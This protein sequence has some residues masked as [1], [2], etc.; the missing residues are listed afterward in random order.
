MAVLALPHAGGPPKW[1]RVSQARSKTEPPTT[2]CWQAAWVGCHP[3]MLHPAQNPAHSASELSYLTISRDKCTHA[4]SVCTRTDIKH[5][6][7]HTNRYT[8]TYKHA[9]TCNSATLAT[10][11]LLS[12][13]K[14][15]EERAR[16]CLC[17]TEAAYLWCDLHTHEHVNDFSKCTNWAATVTIK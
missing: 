10:F 8:Q 3:V 9:H 7:R 5:A 11:F 16:S 12:P 2:S 15:P 6:H 14:N 17:F 1:G 13:H 4:I